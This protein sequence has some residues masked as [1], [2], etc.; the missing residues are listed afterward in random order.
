[1]RLNFKPSVLACD[2]PVEGGG[3]IEFR[4]HV[5]YYPGRGPIVSAC[6]YDMRNPSADGKYRGRHF[7][8]WRDYEHTQARG[9]A[10]IE[11][12]QAACGRALPGLLARAPIT[13]DEA[14]RRDEAMA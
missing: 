4:I 8:D 11:E 12:A 3:A 7:W 10:A 6:A 9:D 1:M 5:S 14:A 2:V 13:V